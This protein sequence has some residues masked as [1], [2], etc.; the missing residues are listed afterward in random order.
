VKT[1]PPFKLVLK[2][3]LMKIWNHQLNWL[4]ITAGGLIATL[5]LASDVRATAS[6]TTTANNSQFSSPQLISVAAR[7]KKRIKRKRVRVRTQVKPANTSTAPTTSPTDVTQTPPP[8]P[9]TPVTP[10]P[11]PVEPSVT[12]EE[13]EALRRSNQELREEIIKVD[14]K[15]AEATKKIEQLD[16]Q[17]F[18]IGT[19]LEGQ[20]IFGATGV[21]SGDF[22]RNTAAGYR[23]RLELKTAIGE[24]TLTTR[25]QADNLGSATGA[26]PE[27][28]L[29]WTG[30]A[31][32]T[33]GIDALKY[34]FPITPQT[35]LVVAANAG[36]S[37]DFTD[38]INPYFDGDGASGSIS[39][40]GN[41]PSIYY[42]VQGAGAG[43]RHKLSDGVEL[44]LGY[45][46]STSNTPTTGN[47]LFGGNYGALAQL[48]FRTGENSK[49]GVTYTRARNSNPGTGS[50]N[51]NAGGDS[52]NFGLQGSFQLS[53]QFA[54]GGWAGYTQN[55]AAGGDRQ[56][57]NWA[58]TAAAPDFGGKGNLA[59]LLVGQEPR[60]TASGNGTTDTKAGLHIEGFYQFK[61]NDNLSIT[62]GIIYLTAPNQDAN[63]QPA[64]IGALRT[65]FLF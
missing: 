52:N 7:K 6:I 55:Q 16:K 36:A 45:L 40:F 34:E 54:L 51:A 37:D 32:G 42:T 23:A 18:S 59:G 15:A 14:G 58:V 3:V 31:A 60:V 5:L 26:T 43:I 49:V 65:T 17:Q 48:T 50:T 63:S 20:V 12:R 41:R 21:V 13:V 8:P 19:K 1:I 39:A 9:P 22:D 29:S 25:L 4:T 33:V 38:T 2:N 27:G 24:G 57:W 44:S 64:V 46:S 35:Q 53:P 30:D 47:G 11:A 62:P 56:I 28:K 10:P 61:V